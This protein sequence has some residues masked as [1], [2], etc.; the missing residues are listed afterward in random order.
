MSEND[1]L[2]KLFEGVIPERLDEVLSLIES[3][4]A[5]F[6][7]VD[8]KSDF[9]LDAGAFGAIQFAQRFLGQ[10]WLFDFAGLYA[11]H[12]FSGV[13][14][15]VK[16]RGL[17]FDLAEID[18]LPE[19][20]EENNCFSKIIKTIQRLNSAE[21]KY[22]FA[23]PAGIPKLQEGKPKDI[24]QAAVFDLVLMA[25]TYFFLHELKHVI[26]KSEGSSAEDRLIEEM[27][28]DAFAAER[29]LSKIR[30]YSSASGYPED[31]VFM[32]RSISIALGSAFLAVATPRHNL[33][34]TATH[35]TVHD[36]WSATLGRIE[37]EEDDS[38]WLYFA[39]LAIALLKHRK[40]TFP[41]Q[42]V[43]SYKQLAVA[44]IKALEEASN[45]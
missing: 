27:E 32:K 19:Q 26:F 16:S 35:P 20:K 29:M 8:D 15:F 39:S 14:F 7:R 42:L 37:L 45:K 4:S 5:Q 28:C 41:S 13:I 3:H 24:E 34:G 43:V 33:D 17:K 11:L 10:L 9:N 23:W 38:Y 21:S 40:I 1:E 12:S 31:K 25:T 36:R 2:K 6:R 44:T 30:D 18:G 22:D